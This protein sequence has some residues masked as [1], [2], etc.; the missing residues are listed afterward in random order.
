MEPVA[1]STSP[2]RPHC[3]LVLLA[4]PAPGLDDRLFYSCQHSL[5]SELF[6]AN[7]AV[8]THSSVEQVFCQAFCV[9]DEVASGAH[10]I[11]GT[12]PTHEANVV[13]GGSHGEGR[14][15]GSEADAP[16]TAAP[17]S[18]HAKETHADT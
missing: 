7:R 10:R 14:R 16:A 2:R 4:A 1:I 8:V 9:G 11:R 15:G 18:R 3:S 5:W 12:I 13:W 17:P 6:V